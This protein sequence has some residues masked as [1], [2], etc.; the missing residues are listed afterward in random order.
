MHDNEHLRK[1]CNTEMSSWNESHGII[2]NL[3][4]QLKRDE[5]VRSKVYNDSLGIP[6]IG[7]GRNLRDVGLS[8]EEIDFLLDNDIK[9][10]RAELSS[11]D[12]YRNLDEIRRG[13]IENMCFNMGLPT[14]LQ[15]KNTII[16]LE[17]KD[18][19]GAH[20]NMLK[21]LWARQVGI[22]AER[23][24]KQILTGEWQ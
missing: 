22:R 2:M 19:Q 23:L 11:L 17:A 7:V 1:L 6:T 15:F 4:E 13:A 24:A 20:D 10:V 21:S 8:D 5:A 3:E 18:W 14:L 12:W 16:Y 9:R